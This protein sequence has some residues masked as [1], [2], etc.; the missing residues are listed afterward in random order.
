MFA[1]AQT[2]LL[3]IAFSNLIL[4]APSASQCIVFP[5]MIRFFLHLLSCNYSHAAMICRKYMTN[6]ISI[7]S[8]FFIHG[9]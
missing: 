8:A 3:Q 4:V 6:L 1:C 5:K 9:F 7:L 2:P